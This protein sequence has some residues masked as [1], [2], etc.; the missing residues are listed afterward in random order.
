MTNSKRTEITIVTHEVAVIH[1]D[2]AT[3]PSGDPED[4]NAASAAARAEQILRRLRPQ[5]ARGGRH[6]NRGQ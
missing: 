6:E 2:V 1:G 4:G 3:T 5:L